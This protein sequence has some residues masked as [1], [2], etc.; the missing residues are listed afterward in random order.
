M[1]KRSATRR[2]EAVAPMIAVASKR[3]SNACHR[4]SGHCR[5]V[6]GRPGYNEIWQSSGVGRGFGLPKSS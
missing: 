6:R 3:E 4:G 2:D 1:V 5:W